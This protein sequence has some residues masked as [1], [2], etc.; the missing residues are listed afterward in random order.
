MGMSGKGNSR[1]QSAATSNSTTT[2][3]IDNSVHT[4]D[5][6]A[7]GGAV[8][9][10]KEALGLGRDALATGEASWRVAADLARDVTGDSIDFAGNTLE[11]LADRAESSQRNL[12]DGARDL[13]E[14]SVSSISEL[15]MQTSAT[16]DDRVAKVATYA[17]MAVAAAMI[18]PAV[19]RR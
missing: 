1:S 10:S 14:G 2:Y 8:E 5:F 6:G 17:V 15:A 16:G 7:I 12:F 4:S 13:F 3:D 18:L 19:F 11:Y 9:I